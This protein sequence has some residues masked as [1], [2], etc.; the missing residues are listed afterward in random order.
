MQQKI[1]KSFFISE[2]IA[3]ELASLNILYEEQDTFHRQ[4]MCQ[5]AV[6]TF[7]TSRKETFSNSIYFKG[8]DEYDQGA[9]TKIST[10]LGHVCH[11]A[12]RRVL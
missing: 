3:S 2:I 8:I 1:S 6:P 10:V 7:F 4:P 9:L 5:Q 12:G 11:F